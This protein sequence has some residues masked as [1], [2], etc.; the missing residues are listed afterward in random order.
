MKAGG[1]A[2]IVRTGNGPFLSRLELQTENNMV[3]SPQ[4]VEK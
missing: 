2:A 4:T 3:V 1:S